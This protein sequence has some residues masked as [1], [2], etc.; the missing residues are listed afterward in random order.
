MK[1]LNW[2][3]WIDNPSQ[4]VNLKTLIDKYNPEI[5]CIQEANEKTLEFCKLLTEYHFAF[6]IDFA[7][8]IHRIKPSLFNKPSP[9]S[10]LITLS[11]Y[12]ILETQIDL[13]HTQKPNTFLAKRKGINNPREFQYIDIVKNNKPYRIFNLHLEMAAGSKRRISEFQRALKYY[14]PTKNNIIC[15]DLNIFARPT[16]NLLTGW[17]LGL[18]IREYFVNERRAF[19]K[20][21]DQYEFSNI[22]RRRVTYPKFR[23]Q[24]DHILI[25]KK[26]KIIGKEIPKNLF[27]SDHRHL[28]CEIE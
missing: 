24:L 4:I 25:P 22:F 18:S 7:R 26:F 16:L 14:D 17:G 3:I 8:P 11:K 13:L 10:Y 1:I 9:I 27:D 5:I 6:C 23:L 15:G 20:I 19:Q 2:N 12:P 28:V 21:F